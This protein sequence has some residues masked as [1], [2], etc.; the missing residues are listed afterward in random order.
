[1]RVIYNIAIVQIKALLFILKFLNSKI[2]S[3]VEE[4]K[5]VLEILENN[6]SRN[7]NY[8]W[9][10][11]AS[12]GEYEQGLPIFKEIK[13]LY[14]NHKIVLSFFSS[15]GYEVRKNNP[16]SDLTVYL[17]LDTSRNAKKFI[18][19]INPKMVFFV[20]YEFWPNYLQN[21]NNNNIPTFLLA[22]L[23]RKNH[24]FFKCYG[25]GFLNILKSSITHFF[26]QNKDSM[27]LLLNHNITNCILMGDSRFDRVNALLDQNNDIENIK[28][29]IG[30]KV[31]FVAGSTWKEDESLFVD[32]INEN[33]NDLAWIIAPHQIKSKKIKEFQERLKCKSILFSN[34]NERNVNTSKVL[35]IDSIG[36]LTRLYSYSD[37]SYVG[38]GMGNS[39]LHNI[40]E[41]AV[42]KNSILIGKN[43]FNF[44]EAKDL[45]TKNG[46]ISV[47]NPK[48]FKK[49]LNELIE[50]KRKRVE[51]GKIN[52]NYI[53]SNLGATKNVISYL[54]ERK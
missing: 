41:P 40:L 33:N 14:K 2:R 20:K 3:F 9:I 44:P 24:W 46:V 26:V 17:P 11:V 47:K 54:K 28:E 38:G 48:E 23:F 5:N 25:L 12:L 21:L 53:K 6:I 15:S 30:N 13:S 1:M 35:I 52:Y 19:L 8:I 34:L 50:N 29:F 32:Y 18:S 37:I 49:H 43:Y 42:F 7:D 22:G 45:I 10:H 4:R 39:G 31:C 27:D 36:L 51:M 16:I